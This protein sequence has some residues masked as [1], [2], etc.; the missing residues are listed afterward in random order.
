MNPL[1]NL[2][3]SLFGLGARVAS[4]RNIKAR[5]MIAGQTETLKKLSAK[6]NPDRKYIWIHAASLGE[7]EQGRPLIERIK[8]ECPS[9]GIV[10]SFFSP[11][12]YEVRHNYPYVDTVV[13]LPFDTPGNARKFIDIVNPVAAIFVKYEFWGNYLTQ[14]GKRGIPTYIISAIFRP[15]QIFFRPWGG[16]FRQLLKC[17]TTLY[18]QDENSRQLLGGIGIDNVVVAGDTRFDRVTDIMKSTTGIQGMDLFGYRNHPVMVFGSSW[19]ADEDIYIPWLLKHPDVCAVIAPHEFDKNRLEALRSRLSERPGTVMMLSEYENIFTPSSEGCGLPNP[20]GINTIIVDS[21]G[22][23]ASLYR[24]GKIAYVGGGFGNGIH[25]LNE[26][27]VYGIPVIFGPRHQKFMEAS[28][29]IE[30][31]GGFSVSSPEEFASIADSL[32]EYD[33]PLLK[34]AGQAAGQYIK[35]N[36]GA[37]ERIFNDIPFN[38]L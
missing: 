23:L 28:G 8:R 25:N 11:S 3:I 12:G 27:A 24:Y 14:L 15:G 36:L 31:G 1:Y 6:L 10:L 7:F 19:E 4:S 22:K 16:I 2:G 17:F 18:V 13:Y 5:K 33:S 20:E 26:A 29:L 9:L 37:T 34:S 35:K 21:F 32:I 38:S 30:C